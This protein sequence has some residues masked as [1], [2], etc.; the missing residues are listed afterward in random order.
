MRTLSDIAEEYEFLEGDERYRRLIERNV[1]EQCI[2]VIKTAVVQKTYLAERYPK[3]HGWVYD[4]KTG[5]VD[6]YDEGANDWKPLD[7]RYTEE[8]AQSRTAVAV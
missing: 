8:A 2:N 7:A 4:I 6:A 1:E 5:A 3:V